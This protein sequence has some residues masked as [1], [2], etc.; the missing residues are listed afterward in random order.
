[1]TKYTLEEVDDTSDFLFFLQLCLAILFLPIG[2]IW[3]IIKLVNYFSEQK[4]EKEI[5]N[6]DLHIA[7]MEELKLLADLR[8]HGLISKEEFEE[9]RVRILKHL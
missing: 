5:K 3:S 6:H 7:K 2:I 9:R 1:M 8:D 4:K